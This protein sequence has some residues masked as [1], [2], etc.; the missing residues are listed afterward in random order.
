MHIRELLPKIGR[1]P[2]P[3][4]L[5]FCPG[6]APFGGEAFEPFLAERALERIVAA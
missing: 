6:T 4:V 1:E 2:L 5:L 3:P